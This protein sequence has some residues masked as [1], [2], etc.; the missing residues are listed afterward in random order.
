MVPDASSAGVPGRLADLFRGP[1]GTTTPMMWLIYVANSITVFSLVSWMPV[2][3]EAL[4]L[5][6]SSAALATAALFAGS[7]V[8]GVIG[9]R[10]ADRFGLLS[11]G[12]MA[13]LAFPTVAAIGML[14]GASGLLLPMTFLAGCFAF[15]AQTFL[16]GVVGSV[17]PTHIRA[18]GV[19][20][21][22]GI[23]K[24]GSILGPFVGGLLLPILSSG[25]LFLAA[26]C[27]LV[28]VAALTFTLRIL[29]AS[30]DKRKTH[31]VTQSAG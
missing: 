29:L 19:G 23:A 15:G 27:P 3:V 16:H 12:T 8:G 10:C 31:P 2:V 24:I 6:R 4:G 9:G 1:L 22:I 14:S 13:A 25:Q 18:N 7:A 17:Y 20:W 11:V 26:A 30:S 5:T 28:L 21:A